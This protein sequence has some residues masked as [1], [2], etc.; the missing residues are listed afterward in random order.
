MDGIQKGI[1]IA[2]VAAA[3][4]TGGASLGISGIGGASSAKSILSGG[5]SDFSSLFSSMGGKNPFTS[6]QDNQMP[7]LT[8]WKSITR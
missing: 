3:P 5:K 1:K 7:F 8:N 2:S 6:M 4:F